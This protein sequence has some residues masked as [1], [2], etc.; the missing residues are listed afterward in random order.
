MGGQGVHHQQGHRLAE[1][2]QGAWFLSCSPTSSHTV[3]PESVSDDRLGFRLYALLQHL[4]DVRSR[5]RP[6][7]IP[8]SIP[9]LHLPISLLSIRSAVSSPRAVPF[10]HAL[11]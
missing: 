3:L 2:H 1:R 7:S 9:H 8:P 11:P 5:A 10:R 6:T 4:I